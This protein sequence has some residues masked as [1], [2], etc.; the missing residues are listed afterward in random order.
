M[1]TLIALRHAKSSWKTDAED[2]DRPLSGRGRRDAAAVGQWLAASAPVPDLVLCSSALRTRE[3]WAGAVA[4]GASREKLRFE[5]SI[6]AASVGDL[7]RLIRSVPGKVGTA[8][9]LG[10]APG[11]PDLVEYVCRRAD[12]PLWREID[13]KFPTSGLAVIEVPTSWAELGRGRAKLVDFVA[14]RG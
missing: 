10:H 14:P 11:I 9:V 8:L 2:H 6:Y 3:T 1:R 7:L 5:S 4:G 13:R 12:S